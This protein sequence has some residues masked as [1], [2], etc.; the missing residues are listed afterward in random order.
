MASALLPIAVIVL[1]VSSLTPA[2]RPA[3]DET[4]TACEPDDSVSLMQLLR[5]PAASRRTE[6]LRDVVSR[7]FPSECETVLPHL[8]SKSDDELLQSCEA[9]SFG[10]CDSAFE[11]LGKRP[12][13]DH[14]IQDACDELR[15]GLGSTKAALLDRSSTSAALLERRSKKA[16]SH[17]GLEATLQRKGF[18]P[19]NTVPQ[20]PYYMDFFDCEELTLFVPDPWFL[21][22]I[23]AANA[24]NGTNASNA[25]NASN[26]T[27]PANGSVHFMLNYTNVTLYLNE[28]YAERIDRY[29][30]NNS[31]DHL[32]A[33]PYQVQH[34]LKRRGYNVTEI[35]RDNVIVT[36]VG[37]AYPGIKQIGYK[38]YVTNCTWKSNWSIPIA[39]QLLNVTN[40]SWKNRDFEDTSQFLANS[41]SMNV[42][43][44]QTTTTTTTTL[45]DEDMPTVEVFR[46]GEEQQLEQCFGLKLFSKENITWQMCQDACCQ[47]LKC[48]VWQ[49]NYEPLACWMGVPNRCG[50]GTT[51]EFWD[52]GGRK[53]FLEV[54]EI[55]AVN[56]S[57]LTNVVNLSSLSN[58]TAPKTTSNAT[59]NLTK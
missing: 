42:T 28:S 1:Q 47:D 46:C 26:E 51:S 3:E 15:S 24:S 22:A 44:L 57:S 53:M 31:L 55:K 29:L 54:S 14:A 32:P 39:P 13:S 34:A 12:W 33:V 45:L 38:F 50:G 59:S 8:S 40:A 48:E 37:N 5:T 17:V 52:Y 9:F 21:D 6:F 4:A 18:D 7:E 43:T 20:P 25:T 58:A 19:Q 16:Y 23:D 2:F 10:S 35:I 11:L 49:F 36:T 41:S 30:D 56:L 27:L